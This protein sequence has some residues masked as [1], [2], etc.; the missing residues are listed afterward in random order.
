[1]RNSKQESQS[2][3]ANQ[4]CQF[5]C[6][7]W[8]EVCTKHL[9]MKISMKGRGR[10]KDNIWIERFWRTIKFSISTFT[11]RETARNY[12]TAEESVLTDINSIVAIRESTAW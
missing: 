8:M 4:V 2:G 10:V 3:S 11:R 12:T 7:E 1:M 5:L 6:K 9:D